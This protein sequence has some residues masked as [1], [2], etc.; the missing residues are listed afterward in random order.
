MQFSER[1]Q[2][3]LSHM[4]QANASLTVKNL[5]YLLDVSRR[6]VYRELANL[7]ES[8]KHYDLNLQRSKDGSLYIDGTS[9]KLDQL[10]AD[11]KIDE[12][13]H[14]MKTDRQK[15]MI[16]HLIFANEP[17]YSKQLALDF[18]VS[19]GTISQDLDAIDTSLKES[20]L[21]FQ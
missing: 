14:L 19:E 5:E 13:P 10:R 3:I 4:L 9:S 6:T 2:L 17:V 7:E 1:E 21:Q 16:L 12:S 18:S 15:L 11:A 20:H 8:L